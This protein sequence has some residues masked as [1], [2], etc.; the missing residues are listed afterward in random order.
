MEY[1]CLKRNEPYLS[2]AYKLLR[3][4]ISPSMPNDKSFAQLVEVLKNHY[5]PKPSEIIQRFHFN[6]RL[7]KPGES[8]S[9]YLAELRALA[10]YCN[11]EASLEDMLRDR[12]VIGINDSAL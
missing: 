1:R 9:T 10:Q 8:V 4:L 7:R 2:Q 5:N 6:S 12:L 3:T 11:Y